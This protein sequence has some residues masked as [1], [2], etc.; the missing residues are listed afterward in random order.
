MGIRVIDL[1][2]EYSRTPGGRGAGAE[3]RVKYMVPALSE[4]SFVV[5]NLNNVAGVCDSFLDEAFGELIR[6]HGPEVG[7]LFEATSH[8]HRINQVKEIL[9]LAERDWRKGNDPGV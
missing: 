9:A 6:R 5:V 7:M 2:K 8:P 3:F 4:G 1:G